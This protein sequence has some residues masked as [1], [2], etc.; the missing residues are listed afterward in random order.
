MTV[1]TY[2]GGSCLG[3]DTCGIDEATGKWLVCINGA[4]NT[5]ASSLASAVTLGILDSLHESGGLNYEDW[6]LASSLVIQTMEGGFDIAKNGF[7]LSVLRALDGMDGIRL[8]DVPTAEGSISLVTALQQPQTLSG[9]TT[10]SLM[11]GL[12]AVDPAT[13]SLLA[14]FVGDPIPVNRVPSGLVDSNLKISALQEMLM[15]QPDSA[16]AKFLSAQAGTSVP[17]KLAVFAA[18]AG[19]ITTNPLYNTQRLALGGETGTT[20]TQQKA[21]G[22][23]AGLGTNTILIVAGVGLAV[24]GAALFFLAKPSRA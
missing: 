11:G 9:L 24:V 7:P 12:F 8:T 16:G 5:Q 3:T 22:D 14:S 15:A 20:E 17:G 23:G 13:R 21:K 1:K 2:V 6:D 18:E 4:C 19:L 10:M